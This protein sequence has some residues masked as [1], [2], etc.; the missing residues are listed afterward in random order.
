MPSHIRGSTV[1]A[2][3]ILSQ[4][5]ILCSTPKFFI[6]IYTHTIDIKIPQDPHPPWG[7]RDSLGE[8]TTGRTSHQT[9]CHH[10]VSVSS[11]LFHS[12][13]CPP[14]P[15]PLLPCILNKRRMYNNVLQLMPS[16]L[17]PL[18]LLFAIVFIKTHSAAVRS[19]QGDYT[20][21]R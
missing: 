15:L 3:G 12:S 21:Y 13:Y 9:A 7:S 4:K 8:C 14:T 17:S 5:C 20:P 6:L 19:L 1:H 16:F 18:V 10:R 11:S 2:A